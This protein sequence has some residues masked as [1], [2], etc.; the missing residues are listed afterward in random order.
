MPRVT[1]LQTVAGR[2]PQHFINDLLDRADI[3]DVI[4]GRVPLKKKGKNYSGLCPFHDEKTPSFSVSPDKQFFHCFGCQESGT[5]LTFIMKYERLE[6]VE[7][8]ELLAKQM[9]LAVPREQG[10]GP[11]QPDHGLF[12]V[13]EQAERF[14]RGQLRAATEAIEY[15]KGRGLTG[16]I[17]RDFGIGF[18]PQGWQNLSEALAKQPGAPSEEKMLTAGLLTKN[19]SGRV[20]DRF[21]H[22]IMFPIRDTRGRVIGF[23]GR[24]INAEEGPKYLNSPETPVFQ[25]GQE[26]YG[27]YEARKALRQID[28]LVV[29]EGY[30]DVVALAQHGVLNAVATLG[31]ASGEAHFRKLYRYTDE[32]VCCFDGDR[33]GRSAAW[34]ALENALP[35]LNENRQLKL[36]FLPDGEDP[37]SFIRTKGRE[38]FEAFVRNASPGLEFLLTQL[39]DGLDLASLDGRA[40]FMGLT[41]PY[42]QKLPDGILRDL[43]QEQVARM[44]GTNR[45][46]TGFRASALDA[47]RSAT[48]SA[49]SPNSGFRP[50]SGMPMESGVAP[51]RRQRRVRALPDQMI[52]YLIKLPQAVFSLNDTQRQALASLG[53]DESR[54][55]IGLVQYIMANPEA[56]PEEILVHWQGEVGADLLLQAAQ[57]PLQLTQAELKAGFVDCTERLLQIAAKEELTRSPDRRALDESAGPEQLKAYWSNLQRKRGQKIEE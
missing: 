22:R 21:R 40:K 7:A 20:Y 12:P 37:D 31:T 23:G 42:A 57:R 32:V 17:A 30:M 1:K 27:L 19:D 52:D 43:F 39:S 4:D 33:A 54:L 5:A 25:K 6:F 24:T 11:A 3:V 56:D 38:Q 51:P 46:G 45:R 13:L 53:A 10:R 2:I 8:V 44:A 26:L 48:E 29:V 15:L 36:V 50:N 34:K 41:R 14:Y 28:R 18:A 16:T 47:T 55:L 35:T 9:G 49:F